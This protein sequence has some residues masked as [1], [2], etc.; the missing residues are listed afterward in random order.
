MTIGRRLV[1]GAVVTV[2]LSLL[3]AVTL[4]I[5]AKEFEK[6]SKTDDFADQVVKDVSTLNS[7]S[8]A[9]LLLQSERPRIQWQL[10]H[11]YLGKALSEKRS[12]TPEEQALLERLQQNHRQM[13]ELFDTLSNAAGQVRRIPAVDSSLYDELNEGVTAQLITKAELMVNDASALARMAGK[14]VEDLRRTLFVLVLG[15]V[16]L[17]ILS[18]VSTSAFLA[19]SIGGSIRE[20]NHGVRE[21]ASGN[22]R[23]M[24]KVDRDDEIGLVAASFN[25]MA[26]NLASST[27]TLRELNQTLEQRVAERTAELAEREDRLRRFYESP[28]LGVF[29]WNINGAIVD[30]N[31]KFLEM[32]GYT[33]KEL[34][35]GKVDWASMTP[36]EYRHLDEQS[37]IELK[38]KGVNK[39]P[40]EKEY[41]RKDGSR[42]PIMIAGAMIDEARFN[43]VAFVLDITERKLAEESIRRSRD[44]L[45]MRV[46]ERTS[47]LAKANKTLQELSARLLSAQEDERK[48]IAGELHDTIGSLLNGVKFKIDRALQGIRNGSTVTEE[49]LSSVIPV[50][51]EGIEECRRMQQDLRP[52]ILDDLGLLAT[53][54]WFCRRYQTIYSGI[55]VELQQTLEETD[56]SD[57]LKIVIFRVTQEGMNN[58]AKHSKADLVRLSLQKT[59]GRIELALKDNG[60]GFDLN[61]VLASESTKRGLGL[62]SMRERTELSGGSFDIEST[63]G[64]GTTIRAKW[65]V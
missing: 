14:R 7:L 13:K 23:Y 53:L 63:M 59:G 36:E 5:S 49:S 64:K 29:Y 43:G 50:I 2:F 35:G 61:K 58:I 6:A 51:Q 54:S 37:L 55:N 40:F 20:L 25:D 47:E 26:F 19:K 24:V 30:A 44:E 27:E 62:T 31:D 41:V 16:L 42:M 45:E 15:S 4:V 46:Q 11:E 8:Y 38:T 28:M 12:T 60:Q 9:Y 48:R 1:A 33:R 56:I 57:A 18:A 32:V 34:L 22:L 3:V 39:A 52:S 17:L 21:I 10:K 65:S